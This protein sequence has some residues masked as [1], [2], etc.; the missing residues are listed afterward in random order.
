MD[1]ETKVVVQ[2]QTLR[3]SLRQGAFQGDKMGD[4]EALELLEA[5]AH[6]FTHVQRKD[7]RKARFAADRTRWEEENQLVT[8]PREAILAEVT[9]V[10]F[11]ECPYFG[12]IENRCTEC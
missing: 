12:G 8:R 5:K 7:K 10:L 2:M 3:S 11:R 6:A 1:E 9:Q 4:N